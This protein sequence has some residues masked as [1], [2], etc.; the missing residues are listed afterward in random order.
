MTLKKAL[1][2]SFILLLFAAFP[3][4]ITAAF[5]IYA[6]LTG[7][8]G[9]LGD[10]MIASSWMMI[11]FGTPFVI[12]SLFLLICLWGYVIIRSTPRRRRL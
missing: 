4:L 1:L 12:I 8:P 10:M 2:L 11:L 5:S 7:T 9:T 3:F 6:L